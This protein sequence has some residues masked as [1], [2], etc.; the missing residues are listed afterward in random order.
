MPLLYEDEEPLPP[1]APAPPAAPPGGLGPAGGAPV[2]MPAPPTMEPTAPVVQAGGGGGGGG[3][4]PMG[5]GLPGLPGLNVPGAPTFKYTPYQ[6]PTMESVLGGAN[7]QA[8]LGSARQS[9]DRSAAAKGTLRSGNTLA[10]VTEL[11]NNFASNAYEQELQRSLAAWDRQYR[12]EYDAFAPQLEAWRQRAQGTIGMQRDRYNAELGNWVNQSAP[13]GGGGGGPA[14]DPLPYL[15]DLMPTM[16]PPS[17]APPG[18]APLPG[19]GAPPM[20]QDGFGGDPWTENY[21]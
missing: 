5:P 6:A 8:R 13:R 14:F 20:N 21:Y 16:P 2:G 3:G 7:Y 12:G 17:Q 11:S 4:G 1:P 15:G 9:L 10:D 19:G 18:G